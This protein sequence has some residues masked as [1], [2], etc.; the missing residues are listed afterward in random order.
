[1]LR[2]ISGQIQSFIKDFPGASDV[3]DSLEA[4]KPELQVQLKPQAYALGLTDSMVAGQLRDA[5]IGAESSKFLTSKEYIDMRVM[6]PQSRPNRIEALTHFM[7]TLPSGRKVKLSK[8]AT[9][10][11]NKGISAIARQKRKR[12][13]IITDQLNQDITT[14]KMLSEAVNKQF[15]YIPKQYHCYSIETG[16]GEVEDL[17]A[18]M[19]A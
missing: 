5:F 18:S 9:I 3:K 2:E 17:N 12:A 19:A 8:M 6:L 7:V 1:M 11:K 15:A 4:G 13:L 10:A 16:R 14:S